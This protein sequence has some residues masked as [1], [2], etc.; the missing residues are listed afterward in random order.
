MSNVFE[1]VAVESKEVNNEWVDEVI[2]DGKIVA[3]NIDRARLKVGALLG[4][5][6]TSDVEVLIR[7]F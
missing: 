1:Y 3:L 2:A 7:P 6:L 5:R 4:E